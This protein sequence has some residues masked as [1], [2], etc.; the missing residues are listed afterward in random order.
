MDAFASFTI[1]YSGTKNDSQAI[2]NVLAARF[3]DNYVQKQKKF[4]VEESYELAYA[5]DIAELAKELAE[6][7]PEIIF[8]IEGTTDCNGSEFQNF[9][10][11]KSKNQLIEQLSDWYYDE[12]EEQVPYSSER[13][14]IREAAPPT[15]E[16]QNPTDKTPEQIEKEWKYSLL[17]DGT[18][19]L[20]DYLG[21]DSCIAVPDEINGA[22]VAELGEGA[23][24]T[25]VDMFGGV[26]RKIPKGQKKV[27]K[28]IKKVILPNALKV[29]GKA[30]FQWSPIESV[31]IPD[32][33]MTIG[34]KAFDNCKALSEISF[35]TGLKEIGKQAFSGI[36]GISKWYL[37][38]GL[39]II[40]ENAFLY[41]SF[42]E[43]HIPSS[44]TQ[45][46]SHAIDA[47]VWG[48]KTVIF[49]KSGSN[50]ES[51]ASENGIEFQVE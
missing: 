15:S 28:A 22:T 4:V 46:G 2:K 16:A 33:V 24:S 39:E 17:P 29:I 50:A 10:Y 43:M 30:A 23:L 19:R 49:G 18:V 42:E 25:C 35:G 45:I 6:S 11:Q 37:P 26:I 31:D 21:A 7:V 3:I 14:L 32:S 47:S 27:R 12:D 44:V 36:H 51:Y 34:E 40:Q 9:K 38:D 13:V 48:E 20:D 41:C 5:N 8:T 1:K